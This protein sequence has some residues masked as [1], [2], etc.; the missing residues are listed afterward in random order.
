MQACLVCFSYS[1]RWGFHEQGGDGGRE[2]WSKI[3]LKNAEQYT[4]MQTN[5]SIDAFD[6]GVTFVVQKCSVCF[7]CTCMGGFD[8]EGGDGGR[9]R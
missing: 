2:K 7:P 1:R 5:P 3:V 9:E 4:Y 8:E 6:L